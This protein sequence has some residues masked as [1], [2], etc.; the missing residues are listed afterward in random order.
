MTA[1]ERAF[2]EF[3]KLDPGWHN[4]NPFC[5]TALAILGDETG[6]VVSYKDMYRKQR[7]GVNEHELSRFCE[8][9]NT[10]AAARRI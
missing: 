5:A 9:L 2:R 7:T 1:E 6:A 8:E 3:E 4:I 10:I